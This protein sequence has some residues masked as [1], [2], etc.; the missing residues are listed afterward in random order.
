MNEYSGDN[1]DGSRNDEEPEMN[2]E[3]STS[4]LKADSEDERSD[5]ANLEAEDLMPD[6]RK[7]IFAAHRRNVR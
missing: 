4:Q 1:S 7:N 2:T 3:S 6:E 5:S